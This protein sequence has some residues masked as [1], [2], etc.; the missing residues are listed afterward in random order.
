MFENLRS[1]KTKIINNR[2]V[3]CILKN[4]ENRSYQSIAFDAADTTIGD[5]LINFKKKFSLIGSIDQYTWNG[6]KKNQI[7]IKD[8]LI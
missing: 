4:T 8:I 5:Y 1:I 2:H 3:N 7:I 6:K